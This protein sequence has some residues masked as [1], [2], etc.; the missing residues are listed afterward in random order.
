MK[1]SNDSMYSVKLLSHCILYQ[2]E[3]RLENNYAVYFDFRNI[4][5]IF[6]ALKLEKTR[7]EMN[8]SGLIYF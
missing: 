5:R 7:F 1:N 6:H 3:K 2:L 4:R 8:F